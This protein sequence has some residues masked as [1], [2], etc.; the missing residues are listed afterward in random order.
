MRARE[1]ALF[2]GT[3]RA[4]RCQGLLI[5]ALI[6]FGGS[7]LSAALVASA[8][9][10]DHAP[11]GMRLLVASAIYAVSMGWQPL[12]A[13]YVVR[14][15][16]DP[17]PDIGSFMRQFEVVRHSSPFDRRHERRSNSV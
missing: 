1:I 6:T 13:V 16:V 14:R 4:V 2:R 10:A 12:L 17:D 5:Y 7:W 15:W 3:G 11:L 9:R 8:W